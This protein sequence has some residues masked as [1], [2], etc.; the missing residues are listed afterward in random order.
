MRE[1]CYLATLQPCDFGRE[2]LDLKP[3]TL[4]LEPETQNRKRN[5]LLTGFMGTGK[6][7]VA[8]LLADA[9]GW[10]F[11]DMDALIEQRDGRTIREIFST[12]G[13]AYFRRLETE[14]CRELNGWRERV[15]ATGGGTLVNPQNLAIVAPQNVVICLDCDPDVLWQR[16]STATDRPMLDAAD[17]RARL[18]SLL[19]ERAPAY[20]RIPHHIDVTHLSPAETVTA[21]LEIWESVIRD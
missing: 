11:V 2:T 9:L 7:T 6:S 20:A 19:A 15:I 14:L 18:F 5:I 13:E 12:A 1:V 10:E 3:E 17:A 21:A 16:L 4:N 8:P